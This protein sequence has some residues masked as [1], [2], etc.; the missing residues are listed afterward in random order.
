MN[1]AKT[2]FFTIRVVFVTRS[3]QTVNSIPSFSSQ[4]RCCQESEQ[5][6]QSIHLFPVLPN[7]DH[8]GAG[9]SLGVTG[10]E[11]GIRRSWVTG[12]SHDTRHGR[13][14]E[15]T[16]ANAVRNRESV[17]TRESQPDSVATRHHGASGEPSVPSVFP[18][19]E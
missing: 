11:A 14:W 17:R 8:G 7:P 2:Q 18:S 5:C 12:P 19:F 10:R 13:V 3:L 6:L 1:K 16:G 4:K 9:V 15:Q